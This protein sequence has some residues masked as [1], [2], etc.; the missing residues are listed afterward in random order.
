MDDREYSN[1]YTIPPNYTDSG[2]LFGGMMD[3]RNAVE[4]AALLLLVG[5]PELVWLHASAAVKVIV[6]TVTLLPLGVFGIMGIGGDSLL[7]YGANVI[8]FFIHRRKLHFRRVGKRYASKKQKSRPGIRAGLH[9]G[10]GDK[11]RYR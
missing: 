8:L 5:Y 7:R 9:S 3:T 6:I 1:V 4:T 10:Q 2:K 11:K